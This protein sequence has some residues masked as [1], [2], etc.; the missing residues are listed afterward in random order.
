MGLQQSA[1]LLAFPQSAHRL[2]AR[3]SA[4]LKYHRLPERL[5]ESLIRETLAWPGRE[6]EDALACILAARICI[7]PLDLQKARAVLLIGASG[8]GKS[9]VAD[10]LVHAAAALGREA[11]RSNVNEGLT[12]LRQANL[13]PTSLLVM[14][15]D[16]FNPTNARARS[17]FACLSDIEGVESIGVVSALGDAEDVAETVT[18][19]RFRRV[20][21]TGLDRTR[22]LGAALAAVTVS[23][24]LAHTTSGPRAI[25]PLETP[26][27]PALARM[28][29]EPLS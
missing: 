20:I 5:A 23:P 27:A 9:A 7:A 15:A 2:R 22:R 29:L 19:L 17:A 16:G 14:E 24:R 12:R 18:A 13:S 1:T 28:L 8:S 4:A 11:L 26:G 3:L 10:K 21:V 6:L 25:D